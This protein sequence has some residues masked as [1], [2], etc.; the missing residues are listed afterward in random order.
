MMIQKKTDEWCHPLWTSAL[1]FRKAFDS[2]SHESLWR[3]LSE[4]GVNAAYSNLLTKLYT[5]QTGAVRTDVMSRYFS[6]E[7]G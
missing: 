5:G 1:D 3:S 7:R 4:Q 2:I 6:I